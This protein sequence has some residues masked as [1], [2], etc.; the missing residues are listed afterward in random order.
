MVNAIFKKIINWIWKRKRY[1][2]K[3]K[4]WKWLRHCS[5]QHEETKKFKFS[6]GTC[7]ALSCYSFSYKTHKIFKTY[8]LSKKKKRNFLFM[9]IKIAFH[10]VLIHLIND[11]YAFLQS[12]K[13]FVQIIL[14]L[15]TK[16][17]F[18]S[19]N[20]SKDFLLISQG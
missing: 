3:R 20:V 19:R 16:F 9:W 15:I 7:V 12:W 18:F 14:V 1:W 13:Y 6:S 2:E 8:E 11:I 5:S 4:N 17:P 10:P